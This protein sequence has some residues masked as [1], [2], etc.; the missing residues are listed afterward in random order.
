MAQ[1]ELNALQDKRQKCLHCLSEKE[2]VPLVKEIGNCRAKIY[3][4]CRSHAG[5]TLGDLI[6]IGGGSTA[7]GKAWARNLEKKNPHLKMLETN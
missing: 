4:L 1:R 2:T 5:N 6:K 7:E 3:K